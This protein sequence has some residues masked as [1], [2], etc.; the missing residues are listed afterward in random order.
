MLIGKDT[1]DIVCIQMLFPNPQ[2]SLV[3]NQVPCLYFPHRGLRLIILVALVQLFVDQRH[4]LHDWNDQ[5]KQ[6]K[7]VFLF[8][9]GSFQWLFSTQ[10]CW[11]VIFNLNNFSAPVFRVTLQ[12]IVSKEMRPWGW[13]G[14]AGLGSNGKQGVLKADF[15]PQN[16]L[17]GTVMPGL[18]L[19]IDKK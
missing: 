9:A 1:Q 13:E 11:R 2:G 7:Y 14:V 3:P 8:L 15:L 17:F 6:L 16:A 12:T 18:M 19:P 4:Q 5:Q 10:L